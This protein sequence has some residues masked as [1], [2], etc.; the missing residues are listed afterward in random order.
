MA[1]KPAADS[2]D[3]V[4]VDPTPAQPATKSAPAATARIIRIF[5]L[6]L[7]IFVF[8]LCSLVLV[9]WRR[10]LLRLNAT[11]SLA[12]RH[13]ILNNSHDRHQNGAAHAAAGDIAKNSGHIQR[14]AAGRRTSQYALED[15]S[16]QTATDNSGDGIAHGSQSA[17]FHGCT[18][19]VAPNCTADYFDNEAN[20]VHVWFLVCSRLY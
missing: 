2:S 17:F 6:G 9:N 20:D 8:C 18:R 14:T 13:L 1:R 19:H 16:S 15:R 3:V 7:L 11:N 12:F 10:R 5:E 4:L